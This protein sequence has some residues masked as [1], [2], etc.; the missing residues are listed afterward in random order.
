MQHDVI[1]KHYDCK[2]AITL[3]LK[4]GINYEL[5]C[6]VLFTKGICKQ[7]MDP[8]VLAAGTKGS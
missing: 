5:G 1:H 8:T 4:A 7:R 3:Q 2:V 6:D